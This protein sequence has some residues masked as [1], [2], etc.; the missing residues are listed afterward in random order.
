MLHTTPCRLYGR[1]LRLRRA[2]YVNAGAPTAVSYGC[3][4]QPL[5]THAKRAAHA[6]TSKRAGKTAAQA[7]APSWAACMQVCIAHLPAWRMW[8]GWAGKRGLLGP[9]GCAPAYTNARIL[10]RVYAYASTQH[11]LQRVG[12]K[13][14][15]GYS[16]YS[17]QKTPVRMGR[18]PRVFGWLVRT[19]RSAWGRYAAL[20][21]PTLYP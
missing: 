10:Y 5:A 15:Q 8:G 9:Y 20:T 21:R 14:R 17:G 3:G 11:N 16:P 7:G 19:A 18:G 6:S 2:T 13:R 1:G 12:L 4:V